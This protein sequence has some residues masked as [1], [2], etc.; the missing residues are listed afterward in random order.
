MIA[1][2]TA[3]IKNEADNTK[4]VKF[5]ASAITTA[6]ER[7]V[8]LPDQNIDLTPSTGSFEEKLSGAT[9]TAATVASGDKILGQDLDDSGNLKTYTAQSIAD[10]GGGG[11]GSDTTAIHDDTAGEIAAITNKATV[12]A[13]DLI[14]IEDSA[15]S[16][17]KKH[18]LASLLLA[19]SGDVT[20]A[21]NLG[22]NLLIRGDGAGKGVQNS[23]IG[24]SDSD[25]LTGVNSLTVTK[26]AAPSTPSSG[27][28]ILYADSTTSLPMAK[29]DA[30]TEMQLGGG[31]YR[32]ITINAGGMTP[33][34]TNGA[35]P[36]SFETTTNKQTLDCFDFDASVIEYTQIALMMP[37]EWDLG[38]VRYKFTW[39]G[40]GGSGNVL[41]GAR[42]V[43]ITNNDAI[44]KAW[45]TV[46]QKTD[47]FIVAGDLHVSDSTSAATIAGS[48]QI[49]DLV[50]FEFERTATSGGD[51]YTQD[52][53]L[54]N[55]TI[56]YKEKDTVTAEW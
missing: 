14:L 32:S 54:L 38:T 45:G 22:D 7:T 27:E 41:W 23:G 16:N 9:L 10:L 25:D 53:R 21:S 47:T 28:L 36:S 39:T 40:T 44:D 52:A 48:P 13:G 55:V 49:G 34:T 3:L 20:A 18:I 15:D 4:L 43:A 24:L 2:N 51:T 6:T 56:Q 42:A 35:E 50:M 33:R 5:D 37:D 46:F 8:T 11:P 17:N 1:K 26:I 29:N 31:V 12:A 19:G 30:G